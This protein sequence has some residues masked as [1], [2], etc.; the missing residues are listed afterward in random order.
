MM[1]L[2]KKATGKSKDHALRRDT[3]ASPVQ[4]AVQARRL[5]FD[6][7]RIGARANGNAATGAIPAGA[8][9]VFINLAI[10]TERDR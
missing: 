10:L 7:G 4:K 3:P 8:V 6:K 5:P 1:R 9:T 2:L